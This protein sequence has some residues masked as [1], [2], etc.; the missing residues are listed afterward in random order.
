MEFVEPD[1]RWSVSVDSNIGVLGDD[2]TVKSE[3]VIV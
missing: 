1:S 2:D 3:T